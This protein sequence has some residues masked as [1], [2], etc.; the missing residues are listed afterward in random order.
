WID[1]ACD[2]I[3]GRATA[4]LQALAAHNRIYIAGNLFERDP[5]WPGRFFNSCFLIDPRGEVILRYRRINT[6]LWPSPHDFMNEYLA[7]YGVE[8]TFPV[9]D[10]ELGK[11]AVIACGE[12]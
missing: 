3:P 2:T 11:L 9:V 6:A 1:K 12:I 4:P 10:T 8:G 7:E 5:R